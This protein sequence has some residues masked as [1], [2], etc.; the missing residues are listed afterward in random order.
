MVHRYRERGTTIVADLMVLAHNWLD[1]GVRRI[2]FA[3]VLPRFGRH[4]WAKGQRKRIPQEQQELVVNERIHE[5]NF[6]LVSW[7]R[8]HPEMDF[9]QLTGLHDQVQ[10]RMYDGLH[11]DFRGRRALR[12]VMKRRMIYNIDMAKSPRKF[13]Y[14]FC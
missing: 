1:V 5:F 8:A 13:E 3:E 11:L 4:V 2:M 9:V 12:N 6:T 7:I 10:D 14:L